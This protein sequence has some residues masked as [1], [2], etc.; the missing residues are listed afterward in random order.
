ME[1]ALD[2]CQ[3]GMDPSRF[4]QHFVKKYADSFVM[5]GTAVNVLTGAFDVP[6]APAQ[7]EVMAVAKRMTY[8]HVAAL[9]ALVDTWRLHGDPL[10]WSTKELQDQTNDIVQYFFALVARAHHGAAW[11]TFQREL[12]VLSNVDWPPLTRPLSARDMRRV[13]LLTHVVFAATLYSTVPC[14]PSRLRETFLGWIDQL[15]VD[16]PRHAEL[17]FELITCI[18][19]WQSVPASIHDKVLVLARLCRHLPPK[20]GV[21]GGCYWK[22]LNKL[23]VPKYDDFHHHATAAMMFA[24]A[25][26]DSP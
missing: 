22:H 21:L 12:W 10:T 6:R 7:E 2:V 14:A 5:L 23:G 9:P 24:H 16:I 1:R 4:S 18:Y 17:L 15:W 19:T 3:A 13:Y 26:Y 20:P 25:L 8:G 11:Q